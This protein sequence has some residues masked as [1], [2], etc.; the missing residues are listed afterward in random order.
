M[1]FGNIFKKFLEKKQKSNNNG[2]SEFYTAN[3][4]F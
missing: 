3:V 2:C 1:V 4:L